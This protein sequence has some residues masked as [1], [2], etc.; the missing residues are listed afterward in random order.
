MKLEYTPPPGREAG[1]TQAESARLLGLNRRHIDRLVSSGWMTTR[2]GDVASLAE[3][4]YV[5]ADSDLPVLRL[6]APDR[7]GDGRLIGA[8][9]YYTDEELL[10][11]ARMWWTGPAERT[12]ESG[13]LLITTSTFII[14]ILGIDDI[15]ERFF[16]SPTTVRTAF[17]ARLLARVDD[18]VENKIRVFEGHPLVETLGQRIRSQQGAPLIVMSPHDES[19]A[20][21]E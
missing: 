4:A 21:T 8:A 14:G 18:L 1:L 2:V 5:T 15:E 19:V 17:T 16:Q 9:P 11:S 20:S 10:E 13:F 12:L 7:D 6:G 3:R